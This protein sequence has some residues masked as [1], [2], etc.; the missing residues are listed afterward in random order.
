ML[1]T[2]LA[3]QQASL[4]QRK[5]REVKAVQCDAGVHLEI[6]N[7]CRCGSVDFWL[8]VGHRDVPQ[9]YRCSECHRPPS[10]ALIQKQIK[11]GAGLKESLHQS[12][13]VSKPACSR[14]GSKLVTMT[15][16]GYQC[17][18]CCEPIRDELGGEFWRMDEQDIEARY[19]PTTIRPVT[20]ND[21]DLI[22]GKKK[23]P[24]VKTVNS[25]FLPV[26]V[27]GFF[28]PRLRRWVLCPAPDENDIRLAKEIV[29][30][31]RLTNNRGAVK[32][33][34]LE[35][36]QS[37]IEN[38]NGTEPCTNGAMIVAASDMRIPIKQI[39]IDAIVNVSR[40]WFNSV[41]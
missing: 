10:K 29:S 18:M 2:L 9:S 22:V 19:H 21:I 28:A 4:A 33:V 12:F 30:Q 35:E 23:L 27:C 26:D 20:R 34:S 32:A 13:T 5:P 40:N 24:I 8:P 16:N 14:C 31:L 11:L 41:R 17:G 1:Q 37:A 7:P 25:G 38:R 6:L 39:G 15:D 3:S 36:V